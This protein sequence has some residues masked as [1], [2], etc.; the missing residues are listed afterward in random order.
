METPA[1]SFDSGFGVSDGES[2]DNEAVRDLVRTEL[3][4]RAAEIDDRGLVAHAVL[5]EIDSDKDRMLGF[6]SEK[7][8][9]LRE[10]VFADSMAIGHVQ[11]ADETTMEISSEC[12]KKNSTLQAE[13][14]MLRIELAAREATSKDIR[15][16]IDAV[17]AARERVETDIRTLGLSL[18]YEPKLDMTEALSGISEEVIRLEAE[19]ARLCK[20]AKDEQAVVLARTECNRLAGA[21]RWARERSTENTRMIARLERDV[22]G[23]QEDASTQIG[24]NEGVAERISALELEVKFRGTEVDAFGEA[25]VKRR[26]AAE[27]VVRMQRCITAK[28]ERMR[29]LNREECAG[30]RQS[31]EL[32]EELRRVQELVKATKLQIIE[33]HTRM[34]SQN[35]NEDARVR[36][37]C[38][39]QIEKVKKKIAKYEPENERVQSEIESMREIV[40]RLE[41]EYQS[42]EVMMYHANLESCDVKHEYDA[43]MAERKRERS[44]ER[45]SRQAYLIETFE[46]VDDNTVALRQLVAQNQTLQEN[47]DAFERNIRGKR[48]WRT[49]TFTSKKSRVFRRY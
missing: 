16:E 36:V 17:C 18:R 7:M 20:M 48:N 46:N 32:K 1:A 10:S 30:K 29:G 11:R 22:A 34:E 44:I 39:K 49:R 19:Q 24:S 5:R 27:N 14:E 40:T 21:V 25:D 3:P 9:K 43:M 12:V 33:V 6:Q 45:A 47:M 8:T 38:E 35:S 31:R 42:I 15:I 28:N 26:V 23:L 4:A 37:L 2:S 41:E 13:F